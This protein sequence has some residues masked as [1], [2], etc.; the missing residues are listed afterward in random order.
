MIVDISAKIW[1]PTAS[2]A[3]VLSLFMRSVIYKD[4]NKKNSS[5]IRPKRTKFLEVAN[6][7]TR[8]FYMLALTE[9]FQAM[10]LDKIKRKAMEQTGLSDLGD[11]DERPFRETIEIDNK[12]NYSPV[13]KFLMSNFFLERMKDTLRIQDEFN[14]DAELR[15]YS[16]NNPVRR[17]VFVLGLPR[18]GTTI[19]HTLLSLDPEVRAPFLWELENPVAYFPEDPEADKAKR[20]GI[21]ER[22]LRTKA[23]LFAPDLVAQHDSSTVDRPEEC[24]RIMGA[25]VPLKLNTY[26]LPDHAAVIH[27]WNWALAYK[28]YGRVLQMWEYLEHKFK[29]PSRT[30]PRRWVLKSPFHMGNIKAL[31]Q[32]F[33]DA[34]IILCHRELASHTLSACKIKQSIDDIFKDEVDLVDIG[35]G[36][37]KQIEIILHRTDEFVKDNQSKNNI[38][39]LKFDQFIA[40]PILAIQGIYKQ[41]GYEFTKDYHLIL[42]KYLAVDKIK[43]AALQKKDTMSKDITL[44]TYGINKDMISDRLKWYYEKYLHNDASGGMKGN[45]MSK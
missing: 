29:T 34:D 30:K 41:L 18:T 26:L 14:K 20:I 44:E 4:K 6:F 3:L 35:T 7:L 37:I 36:H 38:K 2:I 43:R 11:W 19:L 33:P 1:L 22:N 31:V 45:G 39:H 24:V 9:R 16:Q 27:N 40:D 5:K 25:D 23:K 8:P 10:N 17:P 28:R 42:Q 12:L 32:V 21:M 13:G 15:A